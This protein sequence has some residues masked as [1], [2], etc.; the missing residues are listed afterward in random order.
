MV[1]VWGGGDGGRLE[2]FYPKFRGGFLELAGLIQ[3][4]EDKGPREVRFSSP[5]GI[6]GR[7]GLSDAPA[8]GGKR[9]GGNLALLRVK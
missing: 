3:R 5:G 6:P 9:K 1:E 8:T 7:T 4:K 2:S